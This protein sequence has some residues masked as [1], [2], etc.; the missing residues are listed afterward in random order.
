MGKKRYAGNRPHRLS[1]MEIRQ[2]IQRNGITEADLRA[3]Y[4]RG[5]EEGQKNGLAWGYDS[6]IGA[7][8]LALHEEFG[9]GHDRLA[10]LANKTS[11][12][13]VKYCTTQETFEELLANTGIE[14]PR[15]K[16]I[17]I[18]GTENER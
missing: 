18:G 6:S 15:L 2:R 4:Q 14:Y 8:M 3:M 12:M 17:I 16:N 11:E 7:I 5:F 9:F 13:Q 10:R 1:D